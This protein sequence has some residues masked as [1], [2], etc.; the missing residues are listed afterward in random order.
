MQLTAEASFISFAAVI[1]VFVLIVVCPTISAVPVK[2]DENRAE[3]CA[4]L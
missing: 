2:F 4:T 1:V 3:E